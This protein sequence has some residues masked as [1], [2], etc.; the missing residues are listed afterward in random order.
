MRTARPAVP[1]SV[2]Q[3]IRKALAPVAGGPVRHGGGVRPG[4]ARAGATTAVHDRGPDGRRYSTRPTRALAAV[5]A[6]FRSPPLA[7]LGFLLG[8][9]CCSAGCAVTATA[10][11]TAPAAPSAGGAPVREPRRLGRRVLRRRRHRRGPRQARGAARSARDRPR[12]ARAQYKKHDQDAAARSRASWAWTTCSIGKVR[13]EKARRHEPGAGEPGADRG[14]HRLRPGGSSRSTPSLTDVFQVQADIASQVAQALD[15]ALGR[16]RRRRWRSGRPRT[17]RPTTPTSRAKSAAG[18]GITDP[19]RSAARSRYYEQAMA[20]DSTFVAAWAQLSRRASRALWQRRPPTRRRRRGARAARA[21][22]TLAPDRP[23]DTRARR[24]TIGSVLNDARQRVEQ[25]RGWAQDSRRPMWTCWRRGPVEQNLGRWEASGRASSP[26]ANARPALG[27]RPPTGSAADFSGST[28][29]TRRWPPRSGPPSC[30]RRSRDHSRP[31]RW[32]SSSRGDLRRRRA[33]I[34]TASRRS[35]PRAGRVRRDV[36]R[37]VL[38]AR[39]RPAARCSSGSRRPASTTIAQLGSGLAG[40]Y[41]FEATGPR[42]RAYADSAGAAL[43]QQIKRDARTTR[44]S[45]CCW[46]ALAYA[47]RKAEAMR[48]GKRAWTMP[49]THA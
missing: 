30:P 1:E 16:R 38:A 2:D 46:V 36:L 26:G 31:G 13:W 4:A 21:S 3:A 45:T 28:A 25:A 29:T 17:S 41:S 47:G 44:S 10:T 8:L 7:G 39:R 40:G 20:L 15:V 12:A 43:E 19:R 22:P 48:E 33:A 5:G 35:S 34:P 32:S 24:T 42:A 18:A 49:P 14:E 11:P 27:R 6:A 37:P 23:R 9:G